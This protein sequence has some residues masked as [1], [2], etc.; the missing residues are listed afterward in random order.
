MQISSRIKTEINVIALRKGEE[1]YV[2]LYTK[3]N[4]P[5]LLRSF[6]RFA[7][8]NE[9]SFNWHDAAK[10]SQKIRQAGLE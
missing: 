1:H 2:F 7:S 9:L 10:L 8:N 6:G 3:A 4:R 5:E